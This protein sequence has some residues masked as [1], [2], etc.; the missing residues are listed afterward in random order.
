NVYWTEILVEWINIIIKKVWP[1]IGT[2]SQQIAKRLVEPKIKEILNRLRLEELSNF[3]LKGV[4]LGSIPA[5]VG[6]I[7]VYERNTGRD[8]IVMDIEIIYQ[9]DARVNFSV[10]HMDCEVHQISF[11]GTVRLTIKPLMDVMPLIGGFE[12]YFMQMPEYDYSLGKL[13][14]FGEIPGISNIIKSVLD[15]IIRRGF[16][17]PN[18]FS[19]YFPIESVRSLENQ[20]FAMPTPQGVLEVMVSKGRN[21]VKKDKH[22]IGGK[23][24]PYIILSIGE[25]NISF[26]NQYAEKTVDPTWN[27]KAAFPLEEIQGLDLKLEVYDYDAGSEDDFM[28]RTFL[29]VSSVLAGNIEDRWIRLDDTKHGEILVSMI[30]KPITQ[31]TGI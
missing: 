17:W 28:G 9:G 20:L 19:F 13:A 22:L 7:K 12:F 16:V 25:K 29:S 21:L 2:I 8:E 18:R 1:N 10:Q 11:R 6:G 31:N 3:K 24:D 15:N 14:N 4:I 23:S 30:W 5:R 27:Y 26:K